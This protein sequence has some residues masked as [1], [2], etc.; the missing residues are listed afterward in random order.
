M[1]WLVHCLLIFGLPA[2]AAELAVGQQYSA[3]TRVV[4]AADGVSFVIPEEWL[5][6]LPPDAAAFM[7]GS[8]TR[9]GLGMV[10][11]RA[12]ATWEE[13]EQFLAQPQDFGEGVVLSPA[14]PGT[15]TERG[16][17]IALANPVY[18]GHA[19][20]R[21]GPDN[22]GVIVFFGG[23]AE[24][25][26]DFRQLA[27]RTAESVEFAEPRESAAVGQWRAHL[28]GMMLKRMSSYYSGGQGGAYV[29]GSSSRTL[30]LCSDGS[31]AYFSSSSVAADGG[32]GASGYSGSQGGEFGRW[33]VETIGARVL[34]SLRSNEGEF[35]QHTLRVQ[36]ELTYLDG[37]R[38]YRVRSDRCQ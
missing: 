13:I 30:H 1:R 2:G 23:P 34:L 27:A 10:L 25:R 5:G 8:H 7:L 22:N 36:G 15:R 19:V 14:T 28:A 16:Y 17:E 32:G 33:D 26:E 29:G 18:A 3:G 4:S 31:Y 6:G 37:D 20:G 38:A 21:I 9:P 24:Q 11:M 12:T 35:S